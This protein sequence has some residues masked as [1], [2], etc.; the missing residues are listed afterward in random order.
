MT[1]WQIWIIVALL[2]FL[3]EIFT[4][5]FAV[6]CFSIGALF[7]AAADAIGL[8]FLWQLA[9]FAVVSILALIFIRPLIVKLFY[10]GK[11]E[12]TNADAL[13]GRVGT[14]SEAIEPDSGK[15]RVAIDGDVWKA[16]SSDGS[17]VEV[18]A[19]VKVIS[20]D[21]IIITVERI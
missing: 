12:K 8:S 18:G 1:P 9:I 5:G 11:D 15:G 3:L 4:A 7:S 20:R 14:V 16:V 19:K 6:A 2:F 13:L 17:P 10:K 21:S